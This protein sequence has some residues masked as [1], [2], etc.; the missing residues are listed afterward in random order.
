[1]ITRKNPSLAAAGFSRVLVGT[2]GVVLVASLLAGLVP[3]TSGAASGPRLP[4]ADPFYRWNGSLAHDAPGTVLRTRS[5]RVTRAGTPTQARATQLLYVTTDE[6]GRRTVSVATVLQPADTAASATTR[7]VSYQEPYDALGAQCDPSYTL[8]LLALH[9][10]ST[11]PV[12]LQF[13]AAGDSVVTADY[14]GEDL[15]YGAGQQSGYETLD[16]IRAAEKWLGVPEVSTPVGMVGYSGG[17]IA[18]EFAS[19]LAPRYA[20]DL[21]IVGVAEGGVPVDLYHNLAYVDQ[22]GSSWTW[23]IGALTVGLFRGFDLHNL[24][25]YLTRRGIG[26]LNADQTQCPGGFTALTIEQLFKPQYRDFAKVPRFVGI[27]NHLIMS[28]TGTPRGPLFI[29]VGLSDSIG[30]G[31][32]VE[33][34]VRELAS[35]YR[36]RGVPVEFQVYKGLIHTQAGPPFFEQSQAFLSQ[37]FENMPFQS[38]CSGIGPGNALAPVLAPQSPRG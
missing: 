6:L 34:D 9:E 12:P 13:V 25:S 21:D 15:A 31:V 4:A 19:E 2:L 24:D 28:R 1:M 17:S 22:A 29:G 16:G 37:R 3:A 30:D 7:L 14:E 38:G 18:T 20:P 35:T 32:M 26:A 10:T 27:L 33:K 11:V 23:V 8:Q 5:V 36:Q